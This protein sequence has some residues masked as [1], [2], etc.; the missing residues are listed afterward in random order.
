[1]DGAMEPAMESVMEAAM[2]EA[3]PTINED[4]VIVFPEENSCPA[5]TP[6]EVIETADGP[7]AAIPVDEFGALQLCYH[8]Q[9]RANHGAKDLV[10]NDSLA[11]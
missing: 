4:G 10:W 6:G 5:S 8:N 7:K 11:A 3:V 2:E 1:M 9:V